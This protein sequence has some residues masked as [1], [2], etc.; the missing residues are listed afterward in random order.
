MERDNLNQHSD[1]LRNVVHSLEEE[2]KQS[3][4]TLISAQSESKKLRTKLKQVQNLLE[5]NERTRQ[6]QQR[7]LQQQV[8]YKVL[9]ITISIL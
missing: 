4:T 8:C 5:A 9:S 1:T 3:T 2:L 7:Q 6:E